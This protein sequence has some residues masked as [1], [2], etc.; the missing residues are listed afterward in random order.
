MNIT[1]GIAHNNLAADSSL[2]EEFG[3]H[4]VKAGQHV[5]KGSSFRKSPLHVDMSG[6]TRAVGTERYDLS[7]KRS[8]LGANTSAGTLRMKHVVVIVITAAWKLHH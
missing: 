2:E 7:R 6:S 4:R 8:S 1:L 5:C 3:G